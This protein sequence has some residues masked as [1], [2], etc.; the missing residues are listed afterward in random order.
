MVSIQLQL[1][2]HRVGKTFFKGCIRQSTV[3]SS[4]SRSSPVVAEGNHNSCTARHLSEKHNHTRPDLITNSRNFHTAKFAMSFHIKAR[5]LVYPRTQDVKRCIVPDEKVP[6]D[7]EF[8]D[9][10]PIEFTSKTVLSG[11]EWADPAD[12]R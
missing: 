9:Y 2:G 3:R 7:V 8:I 11:P 6:W 5:C 10:A 1:M 12:P 4:V